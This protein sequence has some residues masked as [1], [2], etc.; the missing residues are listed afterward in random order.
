MWTSLYY[1]LTLCCVAGKPGPSNERP[2]SKLKKQLYCCMEKKLKNSNTKLRN[3]TQN[4]KTQR[5]AYN[6]GK[7]R[8]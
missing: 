5:D 2:N 3:K 6:S 7:L 4:S 8:T 1:D